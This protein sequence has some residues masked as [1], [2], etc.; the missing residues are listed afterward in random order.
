V[1]ELE[2]QLEV[3][4]SIAMVGSIIIIELVMEHIG[5]VVRAKAKHITVEVTSEAVRLVVAR[6]ESKEAANTTSIATVATAADTKLA[7]LEQAIGKFM[8]VTAGNSKAIELMAVSNLAP[9]AVSIP[10]FKQVGIGVTGVLVDMLATV[11]KA[12]SSK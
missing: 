2:V 10:R 8:A 7:K 9:V 5:L 12:T 11:D 4:V 1:L 6:H 3:V